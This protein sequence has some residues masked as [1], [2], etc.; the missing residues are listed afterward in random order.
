MQQKFC[1]DEKFLNGSLFV[2]GR[3]RYGIASNL[4][5]HFLPDFMQFIKEIL[6]EDEALCLVDYELECLL[7][8]LATIRS[9]EIQE[10]RSVAQLREHVLELIR[11]SASFWVRNSTIWNRIEG[12][13][14]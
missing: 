4:N 3:P 9:M 8:E 1:T 13:A 6:T 2:P 12:H 14:E 7:M 11:K 5:I 10:C